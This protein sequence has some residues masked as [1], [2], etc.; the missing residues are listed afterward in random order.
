MNKKGNVVAI[1]YMV[2]IL[3]VVLVLG[4][5]LA[6]GSMII[7]WTF[8]EAVPELSNLG[9]VGSANLTEVAGYTLSPVN[10][11]IQ[12]FTWLAG[13]LYIFSFIGCLGLAFAFR[14]TGSKWMM[15][16]FIACIF[17]LVVA[18][19]FISNIYEDF[20]TGTDDVA[21]RLQEQQILSFLILYSPMI[22]CVIGFLCGII[23]FT[24]EGE[25]QYTI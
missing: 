11:V 21:T 4:M 24:G 19:I 18:S 22:M 15:G 9:Q 8:D 12:S 7:N 13:L 2:L 23:M 10:S 17:M 3:F 16:L 6:F 25:E 14:F 20:Y 5:F 1:I